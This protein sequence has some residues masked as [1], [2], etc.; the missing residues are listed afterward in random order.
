M[1]ASV[2][3]L[4]VSFLTRQFS[5]DNSEVAR[6]LLRVFRKGLLMINAP[7]TVLHKA[8]LVRRLWSPPDFETQIF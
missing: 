5:E 8:L 1:W 2:H 7:Y 4:F 6:V 3:E